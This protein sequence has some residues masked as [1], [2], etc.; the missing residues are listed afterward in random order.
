MPSSNVTCFN[1]IVREGSN[2]DDASTLLVVMTSPASGW[3]RSAGVCPVVSNGSLLL[4]PLDAG[5][6]PSL[7]RPSSL[8]SPWGLVSE[9]MAVTCEAV[10]R[11]EV[12]VVAET[13]VDVAVVV[14]VV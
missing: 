12:E 5:C 10:V 13:E 1:D 8:L 9:G 2:E 14:G 7:V 6:K 11:S 4:K 3:G